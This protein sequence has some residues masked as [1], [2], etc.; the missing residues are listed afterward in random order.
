M[1]RH[2]DLFQHR[3]E[4]RSLAFSPDGSILATGS[5]DN[6]AI[7]WD[8]KGM[9]IEVLKGHSH[10]VESVEFWGSE[11]SFK[12]VTASSDRTIKIWEVPKFARSVLR[13]GAPVRNVLILTDSKT[14]ISRERQ[15]G[16]VKRWDLETGVG[17]AFSAGTSFAAS[18]E[19]VA[20][21]TDRSIELWRPT[22]WDLPP[23]I[24]TTPSDVR[25]TAL[26]FS[27]NGKLA[28]GFDNGCIL[29]WDS[30][31]DEARTRL[32]D[33]KHLN[34][35]TSLSFSGD[36]KILASTGWDGVCLLHRPEDGNGRQLA[37]TVNDGI[38]TVRFSPQGSFLAFGGFD[39]M[40]HLWRCD[41][42]IERFVS[43][44]QLNG[45]SD[46]IDDLVFSPMSEP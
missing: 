13:V 24:V 40:V 43:M 45:H 38:M 6:T 30:L 5:R 31:R 25:V 19:V 23:D 28:A 46:G 44:G 35:V 34:A 9:P 27:Q 11:D 21:G 15:T 33:T 26:T 41:E 12:L 20:I 17:V 39:N 8:A 14:V 32:M 10:N 18:R 22:N 1:R 2:S 37:D 42:D 4:I 29:V 16:I 7:L 3:D 36:G